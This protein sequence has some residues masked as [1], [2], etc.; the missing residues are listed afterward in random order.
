[1][2]SPSRPGTSDTERPGAGPAP[3]APAS[4][5]VEGVRWTRRLAET[6]EIGVI[7]ACVVVFVAIWVTRG[8]FASLT[9]LQV[10]GRDLAEFGILAVGESFVILTGGID[11]S[12]GS[13][14]ALSGV[15]V[16]WLAVDVGLPS[17]VAIVVTLVLT[18]AIGAMHGVLVTRLGVP[19]FVM[20]LVTL[21]AARGVAQAITSSVPITVD[22]PTFTAINRTNLALVPVPTIIFVVIALAAWFFLERTYV[23]RQVY[24]V[25]GNR[26]AARL[27]GIPTDRR[28]VTAYVASATLAGVVGVLLTAK[29][30]LGEPS[31]GTGYELTAIAAAVIG[32]VSLF[33]G[34]GR[35]AGI[36]A[37]SVLLV[38]INNGL[39]VLNVSPYYTQIVLGVV[40]GIAIVID[41][42]R[43]KRLGRT[44]KRRTRATGRPDVARGAPR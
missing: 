5:P 16:A 41:R 43:A 26:E 25:G 23:G 27:A 1:M 20:T 11:L 15:F 34:Q 24:A 7:G 22:L 32:G 21:T 18:A 3:P 17:P 38:V 39:I 10:M 9:N 28:V 37:G 44:R 13:L 40:L 2:T 35:I 6:P 36:V 31:V 8:S 30:G 42:L 33:G 14:T 19:P 4:A 12:V 29:L